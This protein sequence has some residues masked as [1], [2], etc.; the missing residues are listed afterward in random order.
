[1]KKGF[2]LLEWVIAFAILILVWGSTAPGLVH[3]MRS[4]KRMTQNHPIQESVRTFRLFEKDL[5]T[6]I[7]GFEGDPLHVTF[8]SFEEK[9]KYEWRDK[10]IYVIRNVLKGRAFHK[11]EVL[12]K[13]IEECRWQYLVKGE[14]QGIFKTGDF[15]EAIQ[16][17]FEK[18]GEIFQMFYPIRTERS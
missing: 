8:R 9:I 17:Q 2:T 10:N 7:K 6:G 14:W 4:L 13:N 5:T 3:L 1:M 12:L 11:E 15:P 18:D 16:W